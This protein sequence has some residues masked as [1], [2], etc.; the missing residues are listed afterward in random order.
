MEGC[1]CLPDFVASGGACVAAS[2]CGCIYEGRP[3]APGQQVWAD[4][5]CRRCCTCDNATREVHCK[6]TQGCPAGER[7]LV[8]N[9]ILGC[10]AD[11]FGSCQA[12]GDP[13]YVSFDGRRFD[14]MGTCTYLM[15]GS[16]GQNAMLPDFRVLVENEHRGSQTVSYTRAVRVEALGVKVEVRR[17]YPGRVLVSNAASGAGGKGRTSFQRVSGA[18]G[19]LEDV[20][21]AVKALAPQPGVLPLPGCVTLSLGAFV[22]SS[23]KRDNKRVPPSRRCFS[24]WLWGFDQLIFVGYLKR[25]LGTKQIFS[26]C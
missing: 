20:W 26:K 3:L 11:H 25:G 8:K 5:Q 24:R 19:L 23:V 2:S 22:L 13:H 4:S 6:D 12:S 14:F 16:S 21:S 10:H 1:T 15:S 9:D 18:G 7:C 17:Q